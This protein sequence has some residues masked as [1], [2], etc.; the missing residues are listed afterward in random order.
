MTFSDDELAALASGNVSI[1]VFFRLETDP[2]VRL[3][4]GFGDIAPGVNVL[5][6]TG[7]IYHGFGELRDVPAFKQLLNGAAERV[8]FNLSGVSGEL[9][10]LASGSDANVVKGKPA[11][12]GFALMDADWALI[13]PVHWCAFYVADFLSVGQQPVDAPEAT[14]LRAITLSCGTR[15]TGRRR[16]SFSYFSDSDQQARYPGDLFCSLTPNYAH[17]YNKPWPTF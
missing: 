2:I 10:T 8:E 14:P 15:F 3:W 13:G 12:L 16:P 11:T 17:G 4:L 6:V 7:A 1:G 5:D 9:L